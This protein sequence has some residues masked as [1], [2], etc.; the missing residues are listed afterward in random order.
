MGKSALFGFTSIPR[1]FRWFGYTAN[2]SM[3]T[4]GWRKQKLME[5]KN[6]KQKE[7][8]K[9]QNAKRRKDE[10]NRNVETDMLRY[11]GSCRTT[12]KKKAKLEKMK[13]VN[14]KNK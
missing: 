7:D 6:T 2:T 14:I 1:S 12:E 9:L 3:P 5:R 13:D 10:K 11:M 4:N 8:E